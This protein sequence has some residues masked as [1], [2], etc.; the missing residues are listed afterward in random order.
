[1]RSGLGTGSAAPGVGERCC[2]VGRVASAGLGA[3]GLDRAAGVVVG[4]RAAGAG[5]RA[6]LPGA[7]ALGLPV[8]AV[9]AT[10]YSL[11]LLAADLWL[12]GIVFLLGCLY[13]YLRR[14]H[15]DD[16]LALGLAPGSGG[17][18]RLVGIGVDP[19]L[20]ADGLLGQLAG[21]YPSELSVGNSVGR[22]I[23]QRRRELCRDDGLGGACDGAAH[24]VS[25]TPCAPQ[26]H[27]N[28]HSQDQCLGSCLGASLGRYTIGDFA[29]VWLVATAAS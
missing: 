12:A 1:M 18:C 29:G 16:V 26:S 22:S 6:R 4:L 28:P 2:A 10:R 9:G 24:L 17:A 14:G 15:A 7:M 20:S 8:L 25:T 23:G 21:A 3:A 11:S 19:W 5:G 13:P 27:S